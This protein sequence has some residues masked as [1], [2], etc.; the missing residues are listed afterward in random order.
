VPTAFRGPFDKLLTLM[1]AGFFSS[2]LIQF[3]INPIFQIAKRTAPLIGAALTA[4]AVNVL[5]MQVLPKSKD[6]S[7]L[8]IAQ[9]G[10]YVAALVVL[11]VVASFSKA[12]WPRLRDLALTALG[13]AAMAAALLPLRNHSPGFTTLAE[14][15]LAGALIYGLFVICFDIADMRKIL[16]SRLRPIVARFQAS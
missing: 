3:G 4:C 9:S 6:A 5:L 7:S 14:Q 12:Q 11:I 16:I 1:M 15:I 2:A 13:T 10:A 8:A